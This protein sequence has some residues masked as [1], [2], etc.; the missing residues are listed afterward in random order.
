M[1]VCEGKLWDESKGCFVGLDMEGGEIVCGIM[2]DM[3]LFIV[4]LIIIIL[5]FMI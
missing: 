5:I 2:I 3:V 4:V 1:W